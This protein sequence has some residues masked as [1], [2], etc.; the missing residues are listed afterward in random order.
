MNP[1]DKAAIERMIMR[2]GSVNELHDDASIVGALMP[3]TGIVSPDRFRALL[4]EAVCHHHTVKRGKAGA[5]ASATWS[6][7]GGRSK[8]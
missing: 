8:A 7:P 5:T 6:R 3:E 1:T 4:E 2:I